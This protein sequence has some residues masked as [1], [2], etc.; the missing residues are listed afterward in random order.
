MSK[1]TITEGQV[2]TGVMFNEPMRV[3][4]TRQSGAAGRDS[5]TSGTELR[6]IP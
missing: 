1:G 6:A 2:L 5:R 4:T 3:V